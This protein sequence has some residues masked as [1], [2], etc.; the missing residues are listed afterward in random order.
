MW[1]KKTMN[2]KYILIY[3]LKLR[4]IKIYINSSEL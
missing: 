4:A 3:G 2:G 1:M